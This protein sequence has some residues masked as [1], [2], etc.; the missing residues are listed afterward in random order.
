MIMDNADW[1]RGDTCPYCGSED[2]YFDYDDNAWWC[3]E[4]EST[5]V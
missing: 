5:W 4:C 2:T 1:K 3:D